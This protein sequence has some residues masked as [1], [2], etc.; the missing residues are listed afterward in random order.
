MC[1]M[2]TRRTFIF[3]TL[4][5]LPLSLIAARHVKYKE[6]LKMI[7]GLF[8]AELSCRCGARGAPPFDHGGCVD[9][10]RG[11]IWDPKARKSI[12]MK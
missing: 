8:A 12:L 10:V 5:A 2:D 3:T 9:Q 6:L 7:Q 11:N 4:D 1:L